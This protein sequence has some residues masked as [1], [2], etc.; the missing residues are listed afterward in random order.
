MADEE[1]GLLM[2]ETSGGV[3]TSMPKDSPSVVIEPVTPGGLGARVNAKDFY[4][5]SS[6]GTESRA[7]MRSSG[8][9]GHT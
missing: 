2:G 1:K 5:G 6:S 7:L 9:D 3:G 8:S 4:Q